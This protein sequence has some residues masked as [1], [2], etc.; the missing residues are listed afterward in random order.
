MKLFL[1]CLLFLTLLTTSFYSQNKNIP[2]LS[3]KALVGQTVGYTDIEIHYSSPA[4]KEREIW[5]KLVPYN[6]VWR[7]GANEATT[8]EFHDDVKFDNN[9][10]PAGKYSFFLIP[11]NNSWTVIL[12]KVYD[13]WGAFKYEQEKDQLRFKVK[14]K[15]NDFE[16]RLKYD[17]EYVSAYQANIILKWE[18]LKVSFLVNSEKEKSK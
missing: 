6:K 18:N 2:R 7:A 4:V 17:F 1:K 9:F 3:P 14:P 16:E 15:D 8:I 11:T 13:Q 10:V 12:N 5:G